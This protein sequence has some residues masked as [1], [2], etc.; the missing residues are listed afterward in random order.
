[1]GRKASLAVLAIVVAF[2]LYVG[3]SSVAGYDYV[4][5][6][7]MA[8]GGFRPIAK[9]REHRFLG[10]VQEDTARF[11]GDDKDVTFQST[12]WVDWANYWAAADDGSKSGEWLA[13]TGFLR[14]FLKVGFGTDG[15]MMDLEY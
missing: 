2:G 7:S 15:A 9:T 3:I 11:R 4:A 1:M 6:T 13:F 8:W 5:C 12:P 14:H 10:K